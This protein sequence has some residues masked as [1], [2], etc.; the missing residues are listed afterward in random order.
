MVTEP[1]GGFGIY[2]H[3]P[4]CLAKCPYCDFN[5]HVRHRPV[6]QSDYANALVQELK[7]FAQLTRGRTVGSIFFGGGTPSLM[8]PDTVETVLEAISKEWS[9]AT[10]VEISMEANPTSVEATRF[11]GYRAAGVNRLSV[12]IQ[13]LNDKDLKVLGRQHTVSEAIQAVEIARKTFSRISFDLIYARPEQTLQGWQDEINLAIDLAADH[14]SMYQLTIEEGTM[15]H[16][17]YAA[18]KMKELDA[19]TSADLYELT[20]EITAQRGLPAYEVS[21]HAVPG[22]ECKHNLVYWRYG[23]YVGVGPGAHGRITKSDGV[24]L[25]TSMEKHPEQWM[26]AVE[27]SGTGLIEETVL[28]H[29]EQSDELALMGLRL[30]EG[31]DVR[32]YEE[33]ARRS[34][35]MERLCELQANG[36][37]EWMSN[38]HIRATAHGRA[39]LNYVIAEMVS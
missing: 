23:D 39:L 36:L 4:F 19:D 20:Q 32:R 16:R 25:A 3:W 34:F 22:A 35:N 8:E 7:H 29:V 2:V 12:G 24:K 33:L 1:D 30:V 11:A 14:L 37:I 13:A 28:T 31:L 15:F 27:T 18:G 5:S 17:L 6:Q 38:S 9:V 21:N 10:D 26:K